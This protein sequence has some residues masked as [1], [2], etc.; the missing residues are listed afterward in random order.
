MEAALGVAL[1]SVSGNGY[2]PRFVDCWTSRGALVCHCEGPQDGAWL[3]EAVNRLKPWDG[4]KLVV[5]KASRL[6]KMEKMRVFCPGPRDPK[7]LLERL[8]RQNETLSVSRWKLTSSKEVKTNKG[9]VE[10]ALQ[11][12]VEATE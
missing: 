1:E 7:V 4:A 5:M 2:I 12:V 3:R 11:V 9:E 10:T 8:A 6:P